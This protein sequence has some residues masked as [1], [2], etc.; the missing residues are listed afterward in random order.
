[1]PPVTL[2]RYIAIRTILCVGGFMMIF[3]S[4]IVLI[5]LIEN[6]RFAGKIQD[7]GLGLAAMLT[8]MRTPGL[9]LILTPF[10]FLFGAIFMFNELN[11]RSEI[12]VM[13]SAGLSVWR[14]IGP[15][16][17]I[18]VL[19]GF[20]FV[21]II[22]PVSANLFAAADSLKAE[23]KNQ[24]NNILRVLSDGIWLRQRDDDTH[25]IIN[26]RNFDEAAD[27]L[28][29]VTVFRFDRQS[30]FLERIDAKSAKLSGATMELHDARLKG[31]SD[32]DG[33]QTPVYAID[34][35][36][37]SA[38]LKTRARA[39]ETLSI[40]QL[41]RYI[42]LAQKTGLPTIRYN[43][44]FHDLCSTPLKLL[45]MILIA[46][47]FSLRP[48]RMGGAF[49]LVLASVGAGVALYFL[50]EISTALG[51]ASVT[52][53]ALA[54]WTPAIIASIAAITALLHLEDG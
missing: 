28:Q 14:L 10:V 30:R 5:D 15:A 2:F 13:R 19:S 37:T 6:L 54:A 43:I 36:L 41:P 50:S 23:R 34:T 31:V 44:R 9:A 16:A 40:W 26:A 48:M 49:G 51:E 17:V 3:T 20:L 38:D 4:L 25:L 45:A 33:T 46:A 22:D 42:E 12:S 8:F 29:D 39:P 32:R 21:T 52:P 11:R 27:A 7:A 24:Q 18:A 1:M 53:A 47:A 35:V